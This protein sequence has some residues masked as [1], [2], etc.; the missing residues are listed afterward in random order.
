MRLS[1]LFGKT[2]RETPAEA[3]TASHRL[4]VRA[5]MISQLTAGVYSFMPLAFRSLKKIEAI[6]RD[7]MNR[8]EGQEVLLPVLQPVEIWQE[9]GREAAM[10]DTLFHLKDRRE[11]GLVLGPTHEEVITGLAAKNIQ[12]YRDLPVTLY[13]IQTKFRDEPRPRAGLI[14]VREF[15]MKDAYSFDIDEAGLD[16]SYKAMMTA[17]QNIYARCGLPGMLV[18]ADSGA[19]GGKGSH[20]FMLVTDTGEDELIYCP[21][22]GYAANGEKAE[23]VKA[24]GETEEGR[25]VAEVATP[26][27]K[28]IEQLCRFLNVPPAQTLKVVF[29]IADQKPVV[30]VIRG[31]L[32]INEVKLKNN[33]KATELRTATEEEVQTAGFVPG[34]AS[35]VGGC[36]FNVIG[37]ASITGGTNF[38]AGANKNDTHLRNVNYPRDFTVDSLTDIARA[39]PGEGCPKC[40]GKLLATHGVEVGH[41]FKLG[42]TYSAK[43]GAN[44]SDAN[45]VARPCVMGCYGIGVGRLLAAAVEQNH[46]EKGIIWPFPI[47]P[48]HVYLCALSIDNQEVAAAAER[49]YGEMVENGLEVLFDDRMESPGV[50]FGDADLLGM[51]VRV[52]ISPRTLKTR[53]AEIKRRQQKEFQL[54]PLEGVVAK[55]KEIVAKGLSERVKA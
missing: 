1:R 40:A 47:A 11:R 27:L 17:Y 10:G 31:D 26:G 32:E 29:Y 20:E 18:E 53:S 8:A 33:L 21:A 3:E 12:S 41:I 15:I 19:I 44:Y 2:L 16:K 46:D 7:E 35:P 38:V 5:G 24:I 13:Q 45:G 50:K 9:T 52:T 51:P 54:E 42:I 6:V 43:L 34:Y 22:C 23:S 39:R 36:R 28:T 48:Y 49:V 30:A 4:L 14:R 25:P 55:V 37:D